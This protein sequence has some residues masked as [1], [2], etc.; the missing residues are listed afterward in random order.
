MEIKHSVRFSL[1]ENEDIT[2]DKFNNIL[3]SISSK[4]SVYN[5]EEKEMSNDANSLVMSIQDF[6]D[7]WGVEAES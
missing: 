6:W 5:A 4:C 1:S 3:T 7:K 2:W